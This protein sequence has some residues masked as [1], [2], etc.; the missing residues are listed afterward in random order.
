MLN[1]TALEMPRDH[2]NKKINEKKKETKEIYHRA[3]SCKA[4]EAASRTSA[5]SSA[6]APTKTRMTPVAKITA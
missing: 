4:D 2:E 3:F 5:E 1:L 6:R